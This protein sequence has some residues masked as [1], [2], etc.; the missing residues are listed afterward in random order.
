MLGLWLG[1]DGHGR[2]FLKWA[3][4]MFDKA[5]KDEAKAGLGE[6]TSYLAMLAMVAAIRKKRQGQGVQDQGAFI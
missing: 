4:G 6:P 1:S 5:L 2:K 3:S